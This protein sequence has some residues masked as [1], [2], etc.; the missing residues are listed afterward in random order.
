[1]YDVDHIVP[2]QN[3]LFQAKTVEAVATKHN[4][5]SDQVH[6]VIKRSL[7]KLKERRDATRPRPHLDDKIVAGWNGLMVRWSYPWII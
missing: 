5:S 3:T 1:M 7:P 6:E 4:I 2:F